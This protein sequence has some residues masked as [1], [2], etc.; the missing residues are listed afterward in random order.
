MVRTSPAKATEVLGLGFPSMVVSPDPGY[1][2]LASSSILVTVVAIHAVIDVATDAL[3]IR[4]RLCL[5]VA[6]GA[7]EYRVI[8]R[9]GVTGRAHT[10]RSAVVGWEIS[11]IEGRV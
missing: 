11:V 3:M 1:Q 4:V 5:G 2:V 9:I 10:G 8:G 7:S 6:V